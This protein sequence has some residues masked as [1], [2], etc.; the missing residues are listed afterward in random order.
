MY[1]YLLVDEASLSP[2][3]VTGGHVVTASDGS[4]DATGNLCVPRFLRR[5]FCVCNIAEADARSVAL[6]CLASASSIL[7]HWYPRRMRQ[8]QRLRNTISRTTRLRSNSTH[9]R[10][11]ALKRRKVAL[12]SAQVF[13]ESTVERIWVY[14]AGAMADVALRCSCPGAPQALWL[15]VM[16]R[17]A[18]IAAMFTCV[19]LFF[20]IITIA[21]SLQSPSSGR[22]AF[23]SRSTATTHSSWYGEH[24]ME[25]KSDRSD[26]RLQA[27]V[28]ELAISW[29]L[30]KK[31]A[32][33][34]DTLHP[35]TEAGDSG[36]LNM[37]STLVDSLD[38]LWIAVSTI[39]DRV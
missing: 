11:S 39:F 26:H 4:D 22:P 38:T 1:T 10:C 33:G 7:L 15:R 3:G 8:I 27:V 17:S 5:G 23:R 13:V 35:L 12:R 25:P 32:Y 9:L 30:Y 37:A 21:A 29:G 28:N 14:R 24:E 6:Y 20:V 31:F 36:F 34:K 18:M 16:Q 2:V 19:S